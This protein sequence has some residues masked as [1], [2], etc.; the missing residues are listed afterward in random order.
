MLTV[1]VERKWIHYHL[2]V[3]I[4]RIQTFLGQIVEDAVS[5]GERVL[6]TTLRP[7]YLRLHLLQDRASAEALVQAEDGQYLP[8]S[9]CP[10]DPAETNGSSNAACGARVVGDAGPEEVLSIDWAR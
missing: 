10:P 1:Q 9:S 6:V 4:F 8:T 3:S 2:T 5:S 7:F